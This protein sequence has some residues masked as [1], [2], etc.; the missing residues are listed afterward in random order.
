MDLT[1]RATK[2]RKSTRKIRR[3]RRKKTR[4]KIEIAV[5]IGIGTGQN[6]K[7]GY[8]RL[9]GKQDHCHLLQHCLVITEITEIIETT[10]GI[11]VTTIILDTMKPL[12]ITPKKGEQLKES[13]LHRQNH[14][15]GGIMI[16]GKIMVK[17]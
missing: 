1:K 3:R 2:S 6:M 17:L 5:G 11:T 7:L 15:G 4:I 12:V 8:R 10:T 14:F 13:L 9:N 16:Q